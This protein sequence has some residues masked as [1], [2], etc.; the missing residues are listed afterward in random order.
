MKERKKKGAEPQHQQK[1]MSL[2]FIRE[3]RHPVGQ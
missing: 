1:I 3:Q 2:V